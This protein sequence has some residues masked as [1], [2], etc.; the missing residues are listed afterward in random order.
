M[1]K[2]KQPIHLTIEMQFLS[3]QIEDV[4]FWKLPLLQT[5]AVILG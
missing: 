5:A 4:D 1:Q 3:I 2:K